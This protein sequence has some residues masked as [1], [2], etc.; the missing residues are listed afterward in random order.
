VP[1]IQLVKH[2]GRLHGLTA[3]DEAARQ[4][5]KRMTNEL[6]DGEMVRLSYA[7]PRN[8]KFHRKFFAML[9]VGFEHWE[10][11]RKHRTHKGKPIT[12]N[13]ERFREDITI[14]AGFYEQT[15]DLKGRMKLT[16]TS[17]AFANMT[18]D[19][20][21]GLYNAVAQVLLTQ[22]LTNYQRND[23]DRVVEELIRF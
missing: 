21:E 22:V 17:I 7:R 19:E 2:D 18:E 3:A 9:N 11:S 5:F 20:F 14:L 12:K 13:F 16:A 1:E 10:P 23:L 8:T 4:Q 15:I 6:G